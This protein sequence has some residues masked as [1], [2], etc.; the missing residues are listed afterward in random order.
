VLGR[1]AGA[2]GVRGWLRVIPFNH[3]RDS[4][5]TGQRV[6]WLRGPAGCRRLEIEEA[7][8][9][10]DEIVAKAGGLDDR[11]RAQSLMGC[12]VLISRAAFPRAPAD[13]FYWVDLIGCT[14]RNRAG[15]TLGVVVAVDEFGAHPVLRLEATGDADH[16]GVRRLIPCVPEYLLDIDLAGRSIVADWGLDY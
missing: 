8:V 10:V 12:E 15:E 14:V 13:Q 3:S 11:D 4:I 1:V 16:P 9:H 5:L 7:R 2:W 6:W